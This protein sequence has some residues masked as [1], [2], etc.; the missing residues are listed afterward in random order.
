M[1]SGI[2][3]LLLLL[4]A[5]PEA[6]PADSPEAAAPTPVPPTS[7]AGPPAGPTTSEPPPVPEREG[8]YDG[9]I[10]TNLPPGSRRGEKREGEVWRPIPPPTYEI[11]QPVPSETAVAVQ[12]NPEL[13]DSLATKKKPRPYASPQR[14]AVEVKFGPYL[15]DIDR[16][17]K[18]EGLGPYA[19]I[20][21][22]TNDRD[23]AIGQP[24]KAFYGGVAFEYQIVNLAGP[25]GIGFQWSL[26]RDKAKALLAKPPADE[27]V[28]VRSDADNT[29]FAVMPLALQVVYRFE[30]LAD[31]FRVPLVPYAKA[32]LNYSFWWSKNGSGDISTIKDDN[33]KV[34]DKARGGAWGFQTNVGG[35]LRLDFL[36]RGEARNLDRATG[37]NHTYLFGEW[38]FS[39]V[40]NFGRKNSVSL[41]DSTWLIG[42]AI[43][44]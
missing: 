1:T 24:K 31:R 2:V 28:S 30:F 39:R 15:P 41:G 35:M 3:S 14:F 4:T 29:R 32:G 20:Y 9:E 10:P 27:S 11:K 38:Q 5:A 36:E 21:G 34:I 33:G 12:G 18:G 16:A 6:A 13:A 40:N 26:F 17:Y 43:E 44:F 22:V 7:P 8:Y 23:E 37:I 19:T 25:L 42:L